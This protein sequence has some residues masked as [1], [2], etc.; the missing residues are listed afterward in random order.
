M[1]YGVFKKVDE[2]RKQVYGLL[3]KDNSG[4][5][6]DH[7]NIVLSLSLKFAE[8][9]NADKKIVALIALVHDVDDY[10]LFGEESQKI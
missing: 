8:K 4:H 5:G 6:M 3:C 10:K 9:E 2:V 1:V 7:V